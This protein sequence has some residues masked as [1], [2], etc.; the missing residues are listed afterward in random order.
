MISSLLAN[1]GSWIFAFFGSF[2]PKA[3][4]AHLRRNYGQELLAWSVLPIML[5]GVQGGA[6]A[7]ILK[8]TFT[9]TP[10]MNLE[11]LALAVATVAKM[12]L[13]AVSASRR[14]V[15][16]RALGWAA[17]S[18]CAASSS[19]M[20]SSSAPSIILQKR[21]AQ[22]AAQPRLDATTAEMRSSCRL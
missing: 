22:R 13:S 19:T 11:A 5:A 16:N 18:A 4:P 21:L 7:V 14:S 3:L 2:H 17:A 8:K 9:D 15:H 1:L 12:R 6:M 10:G 20:M